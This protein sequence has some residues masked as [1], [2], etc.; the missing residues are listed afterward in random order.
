MLLK[1]NQIFSLFLLFTRGSYGTSFSVR[2]LPVHKVPLEND[3]DLSVFGFAAS[4]ILDLRTEDNFLATQ[5]WPSAR[6]AAMAILEH[7]DPTWDIMELG[8][9][10]GLPS[11]AAA[12]KGCQVV[13]TDLDRLALKLVEAAANEQNL[14]VETQQFDLVFNRID[15][16]LLERL[17]LIVLSDV[18]ESEA[19]AKG[20]ARLTK[21][22][23]EEGLRVWVFAQSDRAQR[24]LYIAALQKQS[25]MSSQSFSFS[26]SGYDPSHQ[27]WLCD[28]DETK[29]QYG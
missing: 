14:E 13:A 1:D 15:K 22:C 8:C 19:V 2:G 10:P 3:K 6:V 18:F 27:L 9:G 4:S 25:I 21:Q 11:L 28:I 26:K 24:E 29:V 16:S 12:T 20:A 17:D 23:L 7:A 5:V